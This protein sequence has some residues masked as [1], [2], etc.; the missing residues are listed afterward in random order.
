MSH[1]VFIS[2][3]SRDKRV[4]DAMC[5]RLE[6]RGLRCWIAPRDIQ[7]GTSYG[8]AILHAINDTRV[9]VVIL[10]NQA[11]LSRHVAKE[12]ERAVAK[13][14]PVIPFRIEDIV[15]NK[16]LEYFLSAEH[17]L[18][19]INPPLE[20]HLQKLGAAVQG[21]LGMDRPETQPETT[22]QWATAERQFQEIAPD[23]W[24]WRSGNRL[25]TWLRKLLAEEP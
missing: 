1:E 25:V 18:D 15:P 20:Q 2:H 4:A 10:S 16:D 22:E 17:W 7:P 13:G 23:E 9:M 24:R 19:A 14:V 21:L 6:Q 3:A 11:N 5:A 8:A 12:V